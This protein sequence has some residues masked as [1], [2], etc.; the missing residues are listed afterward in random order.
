MAGFTLSLLPNIE[1]LHVSI[2]RRLYDRPDDGLAYVFLRAAAEFRSQSAT[3]SGPKP[4]TKLRD[5]TISYDSDRRWSGIWPLFP[6]IAHHT[7][8]SFTFDQMLGEYGSDYGIDWSLLP[9]ELRLKSLRLERSNI[10][11]PLL[12]KLLQMCPVLEVLKY[13]HYQLWT[14]VHLE[15]DTFGSSIAHLKHCLRKLELY[16][17]GKKYYH[18]ASIPREVT[19]I[20]LSGFEK[21]TSLSITANIPYKERLLYKSMVVRCSLRA[22]KW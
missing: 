6:Y 17:P 12:R 14:E 20:S 5:L 19:T 18:T 3:S 16:R 22:T 2:T 10:W 15:L 9:S 7:L 1:K 8:E 21:L 4:L 13:E 11:T